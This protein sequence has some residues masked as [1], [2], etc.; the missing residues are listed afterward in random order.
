VPAATALIVPGFKNSGPQHW[1]TRWEKTRSDCRRIEQESWD[2]PDPHAWAAAI[3]AAVTAT[4]HPVVLAA[5]S[6]GCT[7]IAHWVS[8]GGSLAG[9]AGALLVAPCDVERDALPAPLRRFAPQPLPMLPF[10]STVVAS[11]DDPYVT[12]ARARGFADAWGSAFVDVGPLG[13]INA[14]S[15]IGDWPFGQV[16]LDTLI[17]SA[18]ADRSA[19]VRAASLRAAQAT[20]LRLD[21]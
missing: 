15:G 9:V 17:A 21:G 11:R 1:Q 13:H 19:Y 8:M 20:P 12:L 3:E 4:P 18:G 2:T 6:L 5:H 10:R 14:N 7:A 16:L